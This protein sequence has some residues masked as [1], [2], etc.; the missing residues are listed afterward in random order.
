MDSPDWTIVLRRPY[1]TTE[2]Y[3]W[4]SENDLLDSTARKPA[5]PVQTLT[6]SK[7]VAVFQTACAIGKYSD[8]ARSIYRFN[9]AATD[10][11]QWLSQFRS[12]APAA[13]MDLTN[14][15][16]GTG[17]GT[18]EEPEA[19]LT[20]RNELWVGKQTSPYTSSRIVAYCAMVLS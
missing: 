12:D 4:Y 14:I 15:V 20:V 11:V 19:V 2:K 8:D 10:S 17:G 1:A 13:Q 7:S 3:E 9:G 5:K 6:V 16:T 18:A